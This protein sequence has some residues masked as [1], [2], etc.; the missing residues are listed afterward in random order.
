MTKLVEPGFVP[1]PGGVDKL[2]AEAGIC[3]I[4]VQDGHLGSNLRI[5]DASALRGVTF[6][7]PDDDV[8]YVDSEHQI[9]VPPEEGTYVLLHATGIVTFLAVESL[10]EALR[11]AKCSSALAIFSGEITVLHLETTE[12]DHS[13]RGDGQTISHLWRGAWGKMLAATK[14]KKRATMKPGAIMV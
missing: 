10:F 12:V 3:V 2:E 11:P 13:A 4:P 5:G 9:R 6:K 7:I 14:E 1:G 8:D